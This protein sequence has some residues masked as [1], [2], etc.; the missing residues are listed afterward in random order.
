M[1]NAG[2]ELLCPAKI[3][4]GL[5]IVRK[6]EDG[7]HD[8]ET[9]FQ[10]VTLFDRLRVEWRQSEGV[11]LACPDSDLP[12]DRGNLV[13]RAAEAFLSRV[14][15]ERGVSLT[16]WKSIP[17]SAGLGGGSS[18]AASALLALNQ[19]FGNPLS[20]T[21]LSSL[22]VSLGAD[23]PFFIMETSTALGEGI[24]DRLTPVTLPRMWF[25]LAHPTFEVSTAMVYGALD[26]RLTRQNWDVKSALLN[27]S[28]LKIENLL[29]NDLE[30]VSAKAY[31]EINAVREA[32]VRAG[33]S[34]VLMS[35]SG[36]T[37]FGLFSGREA[38][39]KGGRYLSENHDLKTS[40]V[41]SF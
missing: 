13:W 11:R 36:P 4:L 29:Y 26:L 27:Q 28:S 38:A 35:G 7:Y 18:D 22:G 32:L 16:L 17:V 15:A 41:R 9:V 34:R 8:L 39:V 3:N 10:R 12:E 25:V 14:G 37:V 24:G 31:P 5:R 40:V 2:V 33:S 1:T 6:R 20:R 30:K 19:L 21:D 23:V